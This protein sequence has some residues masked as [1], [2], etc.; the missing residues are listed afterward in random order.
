MSN[1]K[2]S[3]IK[4]VLVVVLQTQQFHCPVEEAGM[5]CRRTKAILL[6]A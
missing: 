1:T 4:V 5:V 2:N 3:K 6:E